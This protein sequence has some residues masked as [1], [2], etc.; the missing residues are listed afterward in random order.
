MASES[1]TPGLRA[2]VSGSTGAIGRPLVN[3]LLN[4]AAVASVVVLV[5][6]ENS[7]PKSAKLTELVVNFDEL[8]SDVFADINVVYCCLG[9]TIKDA[10]SQAAFFQSRSRLCC[11][12]CQGRQGRRCAALFAGDVDWR[13]DKQFKFLPQNQRTG[14][15]GRQGLRVQSFQRVQTVDAGPAQQQT[16]RRVRGVVLHVLGLLLFWLLLRTIRRRQSGNRRTCYDCRCAL[17][18]SGELSRLRRLGCLRTKSARNIGKFAFES[19]IVKKFGAARMAQ[20]F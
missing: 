7:F 19:A 14:G 3:Q 1:K 17:V 8:K 18:V 15:T 20:G 6:R 4:E 2:L 10:G 16:L 12:R 13:N 9:T 5:R 11:S